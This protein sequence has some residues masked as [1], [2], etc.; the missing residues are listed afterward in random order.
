VVFPRH[1]P[2]VRHRA[3]HE[4]P[5]VEALGRLAAGADIFRR[6]KLRL[7]GG[8]DGLGDLVLHGE[9]VGKLAVVTLRPD[10]AA[11]RDIDEL[12]GDAHAAAVLAHAALDHIIDAEFTGELFHRHRAAA[13]GE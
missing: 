9:Y 10:M 13:I 1:A 11:G 4:L 7:D 2:E 6:V 3:H 12:N 5:G 8:D